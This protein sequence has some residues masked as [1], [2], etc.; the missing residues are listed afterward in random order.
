MCKLTSQVQGDPTEVCVP[1]QVIEIVGE[2]LKDQT[3]VGAE[4]EMPLQ[5]DCKT[6]HKFQQISEPC[7]Q[8]I[9]SQPLNSD[10]SAQ[11]LS[12]LGV[13][14]DLKNSLTS[15]LVKRH[16]MHALTNVVF[17]FCIMFVHQLQESNF[18]LGLVEERF[19]VLD[20]FDGHLILVQ[21]VERF[22]YLLPNI[23]ASIK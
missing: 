22:H 13:S 9:H 7:F 11:L 3:Q 23:N 1:Q 18:D 6:E 20:D 19:L 16:E 17:A 2:Q 4:H 10:V 15:T 14:Q 5:F 21:Q 8:R 12:M